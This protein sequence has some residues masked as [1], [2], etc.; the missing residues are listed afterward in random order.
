M[1]TILVD[2]DVEG[3][4]MMLWATLSADGWPELLPLRF[5]LFFHVGLAK[6]SNDRT[7]WR[8]AQQNSMVLLT[9]NR[10][11]REEDSLEKTIRE[12]NT[13]TSLPVITISRV[14]RMIERRYREQCE[15][16]LLNILLELDNYRGTGRIFI[17]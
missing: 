10:R 17:P 3:Q 7:V 1:I 11:M 13:S 2:H 14:K 15:V 5:L 4:A 6:D 8:F 12:E 9:G 16:Q